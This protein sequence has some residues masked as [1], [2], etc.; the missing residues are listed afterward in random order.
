MTAL[1][2]RRPGKALQDALAGGGVGLR[3][4]NLPGVS[5]YEGN[6]PLELGAR[7]LVH[8]AYRAFCRRR[9]IRWREPAL[10]L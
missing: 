5:V 3:V 4:L 7:W 9:T 2:Y 10:K 1:N 8:S 6:Y